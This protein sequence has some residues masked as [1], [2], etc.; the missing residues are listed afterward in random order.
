MQLKKIKQGHT[1]YFVTN[2]FNSDVKTQV[3]TMR[4]TTNE[5]IR[6]FIHNI[7]LMGAEYLVF[8]SRRK[9]ISCSK[10]WNRLPK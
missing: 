1:V 3:N 5:R 8:T 7:E 2:S 10:M 6:N 9:A 4:M